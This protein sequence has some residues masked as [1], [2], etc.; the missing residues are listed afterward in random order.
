MN[1]GSKNCSALANVGLLKTGKEPFVRQYDSYLA[2]FIYLLRIR[3]LL[4][5]RAGYNYQWPPYKKYRTAKVSFYLNYYNL[6]GLSQACSRLRERNGLYYDTTSTNDM[7]GIFPK[8]CNREY[9]FEKQRLEISIR[10]WIL[11]KQ[12]LRVIR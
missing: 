9:S 5:V 8:S 10:K 7:P 12:I 3:K 11:Q 6:T 2:S 4:T 1:D